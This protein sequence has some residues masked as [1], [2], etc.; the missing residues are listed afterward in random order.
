MPELIAGGPEI[1]IRLLNELDDG[2]VVFFCGAG[3]SMAAGSCLPS[4]KAL[5]KHVYDA[6]HIEP[7]SAEGQALCSGAWDKALGLL[8]SRLGP[9]HLRRAVVECLSRPSSG[10][11]KLHRALIELSRGKQGVRLVTTNFDNRFVEAVDEALV[12]DAAP[13]LPI[14]KPHAW[15]SL[16]HL[17]GCIALNEDHS[18]LVLTTADFGRAYLTERWAARF[19]TELFREFSVVFVG[20]SLGDPIM[21]YM[22]D[23]LAAERSRGA[24]FST[25]WAFAATDG[26]GA[27]KSKVRDVWRAKNVEPILYDG[28]DGHHLLA[29]TL[30]EWARVRKDPV[31]ARSRIALDEIARMPIGPDDPVVERVVWALQDA[32]AAK[33]LAEAPPI[34]NEEDYAKFEKWLDMFAEKGLLCFAADGIGLRLVDTG[35]ESVAPGNSDTT[36]NHLSAWLAR[37]LHV[38]QLLA[39][40]LRNGGHLHSRL[41]QEVERRLAAEDSTLP[42]IPERLRLLWTVLLD[43]E[44]DDS[45]NDIW[46]SDRY[47]AAASPDER[48]LI[49]DKVMESIRPRLIVRPG[50]SIGQEVRLIYEKLRQEPQSIDTCGHFELVSGSKDIWRLCKT[51]LEDPGV[52]SR[53]AETLTGYLEHAFSLLGMADGH[54]CR[55]SY[56]VRPSI[57]PHEQNDDCEEWTRLVDLARD[58]YYPGLVPAE[59]GRAHNLLLRWMES[60]Q[61]LFR[62]LALHALTENWQSDIRLVRKL[63]LAGRNLGLWDPDMRR[64]AMRFLRLAGKRL[65]RDLRI[66]IVG[67]IHAG[68]KSKK[69]REYFGSDDKLREEQALFLHQLSM[70]GTK[71]DKKSRAIAETI[72]PKAEGIEGEPD[73]FLARGKY[74]RIGI[75]DYAPEHLVEGSVG[76]IVAALESEQ[77]GQGKLRELAVRKPVKV[78]R[79]LRRISKRGKWPAEYWQGFLWQLTGPKYRARLHIHA[80]RVLAEA[81]D[82][83][84][85]ETASAVADLVDR[86]ADECGTDRET[87]FGILWKKSWAGK[88][89]GGSETAG[90]HET[91]VKALNHPAGKLAKAAW[92]RLR[93]YEPRAGMGIPAPVKPYFDAMAEDPLGHLGRVRLVTGLHPLFAIDPEWTERHLIARLA[94]TQ[95]QEAADLWSAYGWSPRLGPDL[96]KAI[97]TPLLEILRDGKLRDRRLRKLRHLFMAVCLDAPGDLTEGEIR[98]VVD[99]LPEQGLVTV[100]GSLIQRLTGTP[101]ERRRIWCEKLQPWLLEY[102]PREQKRNTGKTSEMILE[103]LAE[104][105]NAFPQASEWSLAYLRPIRGESLYVLNRNGCA[106]QYPESMLKLLDKTTDVHILQDHYK[107]VLQELLGT[108]RDENCEIVGDSRFQDLFRIAAG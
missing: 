46:L 2:N 86:L 66:D 85:G 49:E 3:V 47:Q 57:A 61:P 95:S 28:R 104:C 76:D 98:S 39:W 106:K 99:P 103:M 72:A 15:S 14:P 26:S 81:P 52:L 24:R 100:L 30:I 82:E 71:L 29:E 36:R 65:P 5:V 83:L 51:V 94:R 54:L 108:L 13:R 102:W 101:D 53:H 75:E 56:L 42:E 77:L 87:E 21:G 78:V 8:E 9:D 62:R 7:D 63:L 41:R 32:S 12:V 68:P 10:E 50:L 35:Y 31:Q 33:A 25:A 97:R 40:A 88:G 73:E 44:P 92:V 37:H 107:P 64:E 90:K 84:F 17:H 1:P 79:A 105:G 18:N 22:V 48:R 58:S 69:I 55:W 43:S 93:K 74:E 59:K 34:S 20:Y 6:N 80:A 4:F 27:G 60:E 96:L 23:A 67:A 91:L 19:V 45:R 16:V 11:L 89:E 70:S 38:P